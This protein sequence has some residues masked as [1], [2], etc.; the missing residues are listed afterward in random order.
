[1]LAQD[2]GKVGRL[3]AFWDICKARELA[4][5]FAGY[6]RGVPGPLQIVAAGAQ[7]QMTGVVGRAILALV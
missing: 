5:G 7:D 4:W 3:L 2:T 1:M 6:L